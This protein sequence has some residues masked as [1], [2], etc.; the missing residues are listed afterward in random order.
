MTS[1]LLKKF[2]LFH[3]RER[4]EVPIQ[5]TMGPL[6]YR[7]TIILRIEDDEGAFG[8][9]EI[10]CN[11]PP[12][13][14]L[15]RAR[16]AGNILPTALAGMHGDVAK[17]PFDF[18][19]ARLKNL[20]LQAGEPGPLAQIS[21]AVDIAIH[22]LAAK[23]KGVS[24]AQLLGGKARP[25]PAY[26]SGISPEK[27]EEQFERMRALGFRH[28]KQRI[29]FGK[30]EGIGEVEIAASNLLDG[31]TLCV[32]ANQAWSIE[33]AISRSNRLEEL[34]LQWLEEPLPADAP[35]E[36]W[37]S[38]AA[39]TRIPLAA[40][41]NLRGDREFATAFRAGAISVVQPDICKWG[42]L[43][44]CHRVATAALEAGQTYCPHFLGSGVG[45]TAS[46]HLL[47]AV[48]G[49]GRL[50]IDS[51]QNV[52]SSIF[53]ANGVALSNGEFQIPTEPGLGYVPDL[54]AAKSM[55]LSRESHDIN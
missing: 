2:D 29:G 28:F 36:H 38:L 26:A 35:L 7:P 45:L 43:S 41:E 19:T 14:D 25:V 37:R 12:D 18:L 9:G 44:G 21:A 40:G 31:E 27:F 48:G 54:E 23:R 5:T 10:W 1:S 6:T 55:L 22:D 53:T 34:D 32:D 52:L 49:P 13:G 16:L 4:L 39:H 50:E 42:G 33:T 30:D 20:A 24:L 47:A 11:F 3:Y 46:A 8:F 15:H 17:S 51:S